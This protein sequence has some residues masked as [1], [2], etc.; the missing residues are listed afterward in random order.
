MG[1]Q[2]AW[3]YDVV[4]AAIILIF[5]YIGG[6]RGFVKS[7]ALILGYIAAF[8]LSYFVSAIS[9]PIIYEHALQPKI[10]EII[11]E[12]IDNID[13]VGE[14][15]KALNS[16][17]L[18]ITFESDELSRVISDSEN[19]I[20][21]DLESYITDKFS[22]VNVSSADIDAKLREIFNNE[23]VE[24][25][26]GTLPPYMQDPVQEYVEQ[27]H[28]ALSEGIKSLVGTKE[29]AAAYIEETFIRQGMIT[30][31]KIIVFMVIFSLVMILVRAASGGL[32]AVNKIPVAGSLNTF[33]GIVLGFIQGAV[34]LLIVAMV[35]NVLI[36][37]TGN[38]MIVINTQ[39]IDETHLFG[40]FYNF[41]FLK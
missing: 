34:I 20:G 22:N 24:D 9:A 35:I 13:I 14:L 2:F 27:S 38:Q 25:F 23:V 31:I 29:K 10:T 37:L 15:K 8:L 32:S 1:T 12:R 41:K 21:K 18:G 11:T 28:E 26:L 39:T 5:I 3:Y 30:M 6:K 4:V 7:V 36:S 40:Y 19:D 17:E 16:E 33:L